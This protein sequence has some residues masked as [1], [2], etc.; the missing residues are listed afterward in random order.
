[1]CLKAFY[2]VI[3]GFA[4]YVMATVAAFVYLPWWQA[5]LVSLGTLFSLLYLAKFWV[6]YLLK[7]FHRQLVDGLRQ[8]SEAL[9]NATIQIHQIH[10]SS[11]PQQV[12]QELQELEQFQAKLQ[13]H[14]NDQDNN[15]EDSQGDLQET[16]AMIE[17]HQLRRWY[18]IEVSIIPSSHAN[19]RTGDTHRGKR[20][21]ASEWNP[22]VLRLVPWDAPSLLDPLP[23]TSPATDEDRP[24][25][26]EYELYDFQLWQEGSY[27]SQEHESELSCSGLVRLKA[28]FGVRPGQRLLKFQYLQAQFGRIE[29]PVELRP[30]KSDDLFG[31]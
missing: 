30:R 13:S 28:R 22:K 2:A 19:N 11:M 14:N 16:Q 1:M 12:L 9:T 27:V 20:L 10:S 26:D 25:D 5:I 18:E 17:D 7:S 21:Q 24:S 8:Q 3:L 31:S 29:L 4:I 23:G 15:N 6:R